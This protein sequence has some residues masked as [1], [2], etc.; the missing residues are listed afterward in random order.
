VARNLGEVDVPLTASRDGR[1]ILFPR[2][3]SSVND[4]MLVQNF[5]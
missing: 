3:D 4:L 1:L 2:L 5:R